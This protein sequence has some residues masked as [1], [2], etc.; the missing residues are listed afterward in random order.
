MSSR[1]A[2][3]K[4]GLGA[5]GVPKLFQMPD[6]IWRAR[7]IGRALVSTWF[8]FPGGVV[9]KTPVSSRIRAPSGCFR[10][11]VPLWATLTA[12]WRQ[13]MRRATTWSGFAPVMAL[14]GACVVHQPANQEK[15]QRTD[16]GVDGRG[17]EAK[18][19]VN[20]DHREQPG[21]DESADYPDNQITGHPEPRALHDLIGQPSASKTGYQ[22]G[23]K[24]F[25]RHRHLSASELR[26][27]GSFRTVWRGR[28]IWCGSLPDT[29]PKGGRLPVPVAGMLLLSQIGNCAE[30]HSE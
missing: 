26:G 25:D 1:S 3:M 28:T 17:N 11:G 19:K 30:L 18:A 2:A 8:Q 23:H 15:Y 5:K 7:R 16:H 27:S 14:P 12:V 9:S 6:E 24:T 10:P 29:R 21:A 20:A 4:A 13:Q 22:Y